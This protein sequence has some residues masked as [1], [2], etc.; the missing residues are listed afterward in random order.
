MRCFLCP[1]NKVYA[2]AKKYISLQITENFS[3]KDLYKTFLFL[4]NR[5]CSFILHF[6]HA[7][8]CKPLLFPYGCRETA[9]AL[10][11]QEK[12]VHPCLFFSGNALSQQ[13]PP[14][15]DTPLAGEAGK[16]GS[17]NVIID[18]SA[19]FSNV[20]AGVMQHTVLNSLNSLCIY[21]FF[22]PLFLFLILC[23]HA[24]SLFSWLV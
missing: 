3:N 12:P 20:L 1:S 15:T 22:S 8:V 23:F 16:L 19:R 18:F 14:P 13:P 5:G 9:A 4:S 2:P 17:G 10:W 21:G 7:Y 11:E 6:N 24:F